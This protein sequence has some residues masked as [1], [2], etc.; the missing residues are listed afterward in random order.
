MYYQYL[1]FSP[2]NSFFSKVLSVVFILPSFCCM[3][4][5]HTDLLP[6]IPQKSIKDSEFYIQTHS[7][8]KTLSPHLASTWIG[9]NSAE[10]KCLDKTLANQRYHF[11][12]SFDHM[13]LSSLFCLQCQTRTGSRR[14]KNFHS[15][16]LLSQLNTNTQP[17]CS[18]VITNPI[19]IP[20]LCLNSFEHKI[21]ITCV[22]NRENSN[23]QDPKRNISFTANRF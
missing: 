14:Q 16:L 4:Q 8:Y 19:C 21:Y 22:E 2:M 20:Y 15:Q 3:A 1:S 17:I 11:P 23:P 7:I 13:G 5:I 9:I 6:L 12:T 10:G 18:F